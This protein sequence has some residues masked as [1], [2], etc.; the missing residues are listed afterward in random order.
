M[1][2]Q[3]GTERW[4]AER[5]DELLR[6]LRRQTSRPAGPELSDVFAW[7]HRQ[8]GA[9][10]ALISGEGEVVAATERFPLDVLEPLEPLLARLSGGQMAAAAVEVGA[11]QV[12]LE[13]LGPGGPRPVLVTASS[14]PLSREVVS[15]AS[16]TG[17][18]AALLARA[19]QDGEVSRGYQGKARQLRFAVFTALLTGDLA[20]ARRITTEAVP[21]LLDADRLRVHV[22][23]C[24]PEDRD[25]IAQAHQDPSGYHGSGL[26]VHCPAFEE[27]LICLVPEPPDRPGGDGTSGHPGPPGPSGRGGGHDEVLRRLVDENPH[28]LL[29]ISGPHPLHATGEAY[30]QALHALAVARNSPDRVAAYRGQAPLTGLLPRPEAVVWARAVLRPTHSLPKLTVEVTR[31]ALTFSRCAVA[32]LLHIS[33]NTVTAHLRRAEQALG[34]DLDDIRSRA[35]LDLALSLADPPPDAAA[36]PE[37]PG[38][39]LAELLRTAPAVAWAEEFLRPLRQTR[40]RDLPATLRAWI[41]A[42]A[43][44]QRTARHLGIGRN[45]V[46]ARLRTAERLLNRDLLTTGSGVHDLVHAL[47]ITGAAPAG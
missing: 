34:M 18:V 47:T 13:A 14:A 21:A 9:Q 23:H 19:R 28:Y 30:G 4:R 43:D 17:S 32:R 15:L 24:S 29:G 8:T 25:R 33:R 1:S 45:T 11:R 6:E 42:N 27:H 7:L 35:V 38:P 2:G 36:D 26:M 5:L 40:H 20:L 31:L 12:H 22:L 41:D 10:A 44:A 46:R 37:R 3:A 39:A 16:H